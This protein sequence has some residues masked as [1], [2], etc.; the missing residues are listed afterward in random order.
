MKLI[1]GILI[2]VLYAILAFLAFRVS[3][4]G[5]AGGHPDLGFWWA[6]IGTLLGIAGLGALIGSWVH[7]RPS[8]D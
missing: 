6:V 5:W 3:S 8:R 1:V 7:T 2:G 4:G